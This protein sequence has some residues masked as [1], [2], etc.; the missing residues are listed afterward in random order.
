MIFDPLA[1]IIIFFLFGH[2]DIFA[3]ASHLNVNSCDQLTDPSLAAPRR[4]EVLNK[5]ATL[6]VCLAIFRPYILQ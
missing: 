6:P 3:L 4:Q 1:S 2:W 5:K